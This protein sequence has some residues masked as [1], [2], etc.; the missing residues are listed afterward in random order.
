MIYGMQIESTLASRCALLLVI[1]AVILGWLARRTFRRLKSRLDA[2]AQSGPRRFR[3]GLIFPDEVTVVMENRPAAHFSA[4][5]S[6]FRSRTKITFLKR[7]EVIQ[8]E[9]NSGVKNV[10]T[11]SGVVWLTGMPANGDV[12]LQTGEKFELQN[13]WP[14][15][16]EALEPAELLLLEI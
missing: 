1:F 15:V 16:F 7:G 10:E 3:C 9:K 5:T 11:K 8:L 4:A 14:Y 2:P 12:L 13:H 6:R